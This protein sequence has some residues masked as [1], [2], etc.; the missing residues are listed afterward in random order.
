MSTA[1][2]VVDSAAVLRGAAKHFLKHSTVDMELLAA[3]LAISR[4]TLY[5]MVGSRD[6]LLGEVFWAIGRIL[7]EE[8]GGE[9]L[10]AGADRVIDLSRRFAELIGTAQQLQRFVAE[11]PQTAAR[12]LIT[13]G[14]AVHH[15]A[16][17]AQMEIFRVSG[18]SAGEQELRRRA[19][20]YVRLM[21]SVV[22]SD[23]LDAGEI[24]FDLAEPALRALL[25]PPSPESA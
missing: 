8:A 7:L 4:A 25:P 13:A 20:L 17:D 24:G 19:Y 16:V 21:E 2:R 5:R 11:E 3:E 23:V 22:Y 6:A 1:R 15:R 12:V 18:V 14:T 10:G 9:A